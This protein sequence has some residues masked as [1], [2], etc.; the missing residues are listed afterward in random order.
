MLL[1]LGWSEAEERE[2]G[3]GAYDGSVDSGPPIEYGAEYA[4][5]GV[6]SFGLIV[7]TGPYIS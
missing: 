4:E 5:I 1:R 6:K 3:R 7:K 2:C